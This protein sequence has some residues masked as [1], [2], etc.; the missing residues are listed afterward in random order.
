MKRLFK[1]YIIAG[2]AFAVIL[3]P[4][5]DP[6]LQGAPLF[7][8]EAEDNSVEYEDPEAYEAAQ[9]EYD[10]YMQ[11]ANEPDPLKR[12]EL[13]IEFI[14]TYPESDMVESYVKP[15]YERTLSDC[16]DN[17]QYEQL[18]KL[19]ENWLELYPDNIRAIAFAYNA[20]VQLKQDEKSIQYALK[21]Y[22]IQPTAELAQ[23]VAQTYDRLGNFEK[24]VEWSEIVFSYPEF[25]VDYTLR[26]KIMSK[27][28]DAGNLAKAA[29][30]A[31]KTLEV[32]AS[33]AKPDA[34]GQENIPTIKR[35][36]NHVIGIHYFEEDKFQEAIKYF[37][38][39]LKA[40]CYQEGFYYIARC[41]WGRSGDNTDIVELAHDFFAAAEDYGGD[42]ELTEKAREYKE[43]LYKPLHNNSL[44]AIEKVHKRAKAIIEKYCPGHVSKSQ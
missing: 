2:T 37:E 9:K 28:A 40:E 21:I 15:T 24:Y 25:S 17:Q 6:Y 13:L 18:L 30:Y 26:F 41:H 42:T 7:Q 19:A 38:K 11:A 36:C 31:E 27:Y 1:F 10:A 44:F 16:A 34:A 20:A 12:G 4:S 8:D 43:Q 35:I 33:A 29:E 5:V 14:K 22:E 39:A 3:F 32:L 23:F